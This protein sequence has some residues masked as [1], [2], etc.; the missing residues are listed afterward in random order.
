MTEQG[1]PILIAVDGGGTGCRAAVGTL[2]NHV[3][4]E[5]K[6]GPANVSTDFENAVGN[7]LSTV[8]AAAHNAGLSPEALRGAVA[9]LGL[10]GVVDAQ[11]AQKVSSALPFGKAT[12]TEDRATAIAGAL[13]QADGY[14]VALGTGSIIARQIGGDQ[15]RIGGWGFHVSDQASGAWL[16]RS[17]LEQV[18]LCED[19]LQDHSALTRSTLDHFGDLPAV[20]AFATAAAPGDYGRF[21]P[22]V[23]QAAQQGDAIGADLMQRGAAYIARSLDVWNFQQGEALCLSG[24]V[25]PQYTPY[26][27][28]RFTA[29]LVEPRKTALMGAYDLAR[30]VCTPPMG[31]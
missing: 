11:I 16:G 26:L 5:A 14:L 31:Q 23:A 27:E 21:A 18:V 24:G 17:L 1:D 22:Q 2:A 7:I 29:N 10:A 28:A 3:L 25:G 20:M 6:G 13:G 9:H 8:R 4:G 15:S 30:A 12:V 19:G